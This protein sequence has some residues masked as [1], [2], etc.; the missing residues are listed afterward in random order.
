[1]LRSTRKAHMET[2]RT[3]RIQ[4]KKKCPCNTSIVIPAVGEVNG[5]DLGQGESHHHGS[6]KK[7]HV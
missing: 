5:V 1:M 6:K 7:L 3:F 2:Q 4:H